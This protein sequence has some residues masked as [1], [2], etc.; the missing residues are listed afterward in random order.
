MS[1]T[2][3][4]HTDVKHV[5]FLGKSESV[6]PGSDTVGGAGGLGCSAHLTG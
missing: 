4:V 2:A 1:V 3:W 5:V 6:Y